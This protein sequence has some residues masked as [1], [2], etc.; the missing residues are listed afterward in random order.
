MD[1]QSLVLI[2]TTIK[3]FTDAFSGITNSLVTFRTTI[4]WIIKTVLTFIY[5]LPSTVR[6]L[7]SSG[8]RLIL[9][10]FI[11]LRYLGTGCIN[12]TIN[13]FYF[14]FSPINLNPTLHA[15]LARLIARLP[16]FSTILILITFTLTHIVRVNPTDLTPISM[17]K[18]SEYQWAWFI[19][20]SIFITI[21]FFL[22]Y[23][24]LIRYMKINFGA[25]YRELLL[26]KNYK[27]SIFLYEVVKAR[28]KHLAA[29]VLILIV[30]TSLINVEPPYTII[31]FVIILLIFCILHYRGLK[32][33]IFNHHLVQ[34]QKNTIRNRLVL[35]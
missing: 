4:W 27:D 13:L 24:I 17:N 12:K 10:S 7:F 6:N 29:A 35:V 11:N 8:Y 21:T 3:G 5:Y 19:K 32:R 2:T 31:A 26:T 22:L 15:K 16:L 28:Q 14:I 20:L 9:N 1:M 23:Y 18:N 25:E 33:A 34:Y 30:A